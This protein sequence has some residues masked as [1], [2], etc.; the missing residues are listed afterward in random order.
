MDARI[1][2]KIEGTSRPARRN[3]N[4]FVMEQ[5][6]LGW[7]PIPLAKSPRGNTEKMAKAKKMT[8]RKKNRTLRRLH[9]FMRRPSPIRQKRAPTQTRGSIRISTMPI[10]LRPI[11]P[12]APRVEGIVSSGIKIKK[13]FAVRI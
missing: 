3:K 10:G 12:S 6:G 13:T 5:T 1:M 7:R 4:G 9:D 8:K 2:E 11:P